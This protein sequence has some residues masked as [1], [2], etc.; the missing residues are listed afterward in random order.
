[1]PV[2]NDY[3]RYVLDQLGGLGVTARRMFGGYGLYADGF[4]F[5]IIDDA[6]YF[7]VDDSNRRDYEERGYRAFSVEMGRPKRRMV[8]LSYF[9]VPEDVL[10][11]ADD[12]RRWAR[13]AVA[14]AVAAAA[15]KPASRA[16]RKAA[17]KKAPGPGPGPKAKA[18]SK[19]PAKAARRPARPARS[20]R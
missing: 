5:G 8:S 15:R 19:S 6:V 9:Q 3:L 14:V 1:M 13:K 10:E 20:R 7:K 12:A 2:S 16:P 11:D 4:F 18:R 17:P